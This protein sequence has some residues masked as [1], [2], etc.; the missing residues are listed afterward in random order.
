[1]ERLNL[2]D[3]HEALGARFTSV[4]G[5]EVVD[6]YGDYAAEYSA[7]SR[8]AAV[9]DLSFRSRLCLTGADR[10]RFLHG[11][12]T[13]DVKQLKTGH[14]CYAALVTAKG[15][16]ESDLNICSLADELLLDFEPGFSGKVID[17]LN[18]YI[19]ADDV[20]IVE[21]GSLYGLLSVAG[22]LSAEVVKQSGVFSETP[23]KPFD[24]VKLAD[25]ALGEMYLANQLRVGSEG[26]DLFVP[27]AALETVADKLSAAAKALGGRRA[28]WR[29]LETARIEAGIPRFGV[30]MDETNLPLECGIEGRAV[31]Y[32]KGCYIGQEVLNRVHTMGHVNRH[33]RGLELADDLKELPQRGDKLIHEGKEVGFITSAVRSLRW[34]KNLAL[35]YLRREIDSPGFQLKLVTVAGESTARAASLPFHY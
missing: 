29:A 34:N 11:Q 19:V 2:H 35:G 27:A 6:T 9:L 16:M 31:S 8:T 4:S 7:L 3:Y 17:R 15:R 21:V 30:D 20:Q 12:V 33:L 28:G 25:A 22:P 32:T 1:M 5:C 13:Q 23:S 10:V 14:G 18:K 26:L 24:F